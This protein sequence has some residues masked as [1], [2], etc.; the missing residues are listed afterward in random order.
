MNCHKSGV[1]DHP[2]TSVYSWP[3]LP[4]S[5]WYWRSSCCRPA[6]LP[7]MDTL[8]ATIIRTQVKQV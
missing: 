1:T 2:V 5:G 7:A 3:V 4:W 8:G 6:P